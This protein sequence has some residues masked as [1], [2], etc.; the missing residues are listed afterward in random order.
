V[1]IAARV[2]DVG[3]DVYCLPLSRPAG[4]VLTRCGARLVG[5]GALLPF[6]FCLS[7]APK[8]PSHSI[9]STYHLPYLAC[10]PLP[11]TTLVSHFSH[12]PKNPR[13]TNP[14]QRHIHSLTIHHSS[15]GSHRQPCRRHRPL[16]SIL[17]PFPIVPCLTGVCLHFFPYF[18]I[19][20][21]PLAR[22]S[23]R[24]T[25]HT[26]PD[27]ASL[28]TCNFRA[29]LGNLQLRFKSLACFATSAGSPSS[30]PRVV[31]RLSG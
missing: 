5:G 10:L 3:C 2:L 26:A 14:T 30:A 25:R 21:T 12:L 18:Q 17:C 13:P 24:S 28:E 22:H 11:T 27:A 6:A 19:H 29:A 15:S 7:R 16:L 20:P 23:F 8:P 9:P 4:L 31:A 1:I